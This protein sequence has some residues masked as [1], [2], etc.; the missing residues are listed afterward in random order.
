MVLQF[1]N[2]CIK[3]F[4]SALRWLFY[5]WK[6]RTRFSLKLIECVRFGHM[7]QS[8]LLLLKRN[9][10]PEISEVVDDTV[11]KMIDDGIR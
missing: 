4:F 8:Q 6:E 9:K 5:D 3:I 7:E 2:S 1:D 11:K 10:E